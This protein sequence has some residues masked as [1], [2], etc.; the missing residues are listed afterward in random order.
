MALT[1]GVGK[2]TEMWRY[3]Q[4]TLASGKKAFR[5]GLAVY[6][7]SVGKM[8]PAETG[9]SQTD[10]FCLGLF[11]EDVDATSAD[12]LCNVRL[13]REVEVTWLKNDVTNPVTANDIGKDVYGVDDETASISSATSTRSVIGK[14]WAI[15]AT[16]GVAVE[17]S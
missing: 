1:K 2:R 3:R 9:A 14:A 4:F 7:Q 8:I 10:L 13:K 6:D 5:N 11:A 16:R 12:K 17:L 15:D